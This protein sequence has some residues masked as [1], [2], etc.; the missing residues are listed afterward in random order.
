MHWSDNMN[1]LNT[2]LLA[3]NIMCALIFVG[4]FIFIAR[5]PEDISECEVEYDKKS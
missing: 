4:T 2:I 3:F 5:C 1:L